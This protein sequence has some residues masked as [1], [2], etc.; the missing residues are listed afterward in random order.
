[1][2]FSKFNFN[3]SRT[4][5]YNNISWRI[6]AVITALIATYLTYKIARSFTTEKLSVY[7]AALLS[8]STI[9]LLCGSTGILDMP[10]LAFSLAAIYFYLQRKHATSAT[11]FALAVLSKELA[12]LPALATFLYAILKKHSRKKLLVCITVFITLS[13]G[14]L[15]IYDLATQ[16]T[17]IILDQHNNPVSAP[18][19]IDNPFTHIYA[20]IIYQRTLNGVRNSTYL[21]PPL[22]WVTPFGANDRPRP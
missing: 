9:F 18:I 16:Q 19:K 14:G 22:T 11:C 4:A 15:W 8:T 5:F 7:A 6:T 13:I 2:F 21:S 12:L 1:M 10:M 3:N 20:T 17:I